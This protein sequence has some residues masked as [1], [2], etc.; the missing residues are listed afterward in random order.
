MRTA[1]IGCGSMGLTYARSFL[2]FNLVSREHLLLVAKNE[3]HRKQLKK[4]NLGK[5][6]SKIDKRLREYGI[7]ILSV[8]PQDFPSITEPLKKAIAPH[9]VVL[10]VM[11]GVTI[12]TIQKSLNH[13]IVIRAMPNT[14][15]QLGMGVTAF[16]ASKDVNIHQVSIIENLLS[17][18]GRTIFLEKENLL[19]AV[20]ALSGS[21]PAYFFYVVK[22]MIEAGVKMG[23]EE[24]VASM[25]VKQTML[26]SFHL[27]NQ[28]PY[29]IEE[30]IQAVAS[31]G[32][33]T[34][35]AFKVLEENHFEPT[36][37]KAIEVARDRATELS[38][39]FNHSS[40]K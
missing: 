17:T 23:L 33:T 22:C 4:L 6:V 11:A 18:T 31:R 5:T 34:E 14:P 1:I 9:H 8:K 3:T 25:L 29:S 37:I 32:G 38:H 2:Q 26:G 28:S 13:K 16:T 24:S 30:L 36:L 40:D 10:S 21:G 20:T 15:A 35:A 39:L 7:I 27:M 19:D 12:E